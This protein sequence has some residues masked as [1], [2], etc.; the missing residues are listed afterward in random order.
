MNKEPFDELFTKADEVDPAELVS[1]LKPYVRINEES[2]LIFFTD[3][4]YC[5]SLT[6]KIALFLLAKKVLRL[7]GKIEAEET[8]PKEIIT[9]TKLSRGSVHPTLK[10]LLESRIIVGSGGKYFVPNHQIP[11]LK[12]KLLKER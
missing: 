7:V 6:D 10:R 4:G 3:E 5:L 12:I 2:N 1:L 8:S 9:E 11:K